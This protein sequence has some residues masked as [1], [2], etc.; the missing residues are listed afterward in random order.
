MAK[1]TIQLSEYL[2][3]KMSPEQ[4]INDLDDILSAS[5]E[6]LFDGAPTQALNNVISNEYRDSFILGFTTHFLLDEI[7]L[8]TMPA[9]KLAL[10]GKLLEVGS[11]VNQTFE[12]L[13]NQV[14]DKYRIRKINDKKTDSGT[15]GNEG[16]TTQ[17][18][19]VTDERNL[20]SRSTKNRNA[21]S[22]DTGTIKDKGSIEYEGSIN[23]DN[24][25]YYTALDSMGR[26]TT[27]KIKT[28][29]E[30]MDRPEDNVK[31]YSEVVQ[32]GKIV[33]TGTQSGSIR[34]T[35]T[36]N[37]RETMTEHDG[38]GDLAYTN[39]V[40]TGTH[41]QNRAHKGGMIHGYS[42]H[43]SDAT[44]AYSATPQSGVN[45][46]NLMGA[47]VTPTSVGPNAP[48]ST[49]APVQDGNT[50]YLTNVTHNYANDRAHSEWETPIDSVNGDVIEQTES[51][52]GYNDKTEFHHNKVVDKEFANR[53]RVATRDFLN[54]EQENTTDY[55]VSNPSSKQTNHYNKKSVSSTEYPDSFT[56]HSDGKTSYEDRK[57][58]KESTRTLGT[59]NTLNDN[60]F[61]VDT[62][63][64]SVSH[65]FDKEDGHTNTE[66]RDLTYEQDRDEKEFEFSME[67]FMQ[68]E[69]FL[70]KVWNL[71]D[72][73]FMQIIDDEYYY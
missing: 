9:W 23:Q 53:N 4:S 48:G 13:D 31:S 12:K 29:T 21:T 25:K 22:Q 68:A 71:F 24:E 28:S 54:Y 69:P 52:N 2:Q 14:W 61:T 70:T 30:E 19:T 8:E 16:S 57:D 15:V 73:L 40:P 10:A 41:T 45:A 36:D 44:Q 58:S 56:Q 66:T 38:A 26:P 60:D 62:E 43:A 67:M 27:P 63:G 37:G 3:E 7:G 18:G 55:D 20:E 11:F 17:G 32:S 49:E 46:S 51:F 72:D 39:R 35:I 6:N 59:T 5:K 33:Q 64:G 47:S 42:D 1:F 50:K 34:D 65:I